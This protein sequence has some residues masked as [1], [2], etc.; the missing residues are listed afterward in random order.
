[1]LEDE[2]FDWIVIDEAT[3]ATAPATILALLHASDG[4]RL[5]LAGDHHQLPPTILSVEAERQGLGV[6]VFEQSVARWHDTV[7]CLL[8]TQYRMNE[9][10][11]RFPSEHF[12]E[13]RLHAAPVVAGH[14]L[15][16]LEGV[17]HL[18]LTFDPL[19]WI[20]TAGMGFAEERGADGESIANPEEAALVARLVRELL[21]AGVAPTAMAVITPYAAQVRRLRDLLDGIEGLE[22]GTVDGFQGREKEAVVVSLVR[23]NDQGEVGF[24]ADVRRM[25]VAWTRARRKLLVV[26]DTATLGGHPF[27]REMLTYV[28]VEGTYRSAWELTS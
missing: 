11:M 6:T 18:P 28:E 8:D 10:I 21:D 15:T 4:A 1:V 25:N 3:Q 12:Y 7:R 20:D 5:V 22:I 27:Y 16:D 13:G 24:L 2:R 9:A 26:G 17:A 23:S 19:E 14:R